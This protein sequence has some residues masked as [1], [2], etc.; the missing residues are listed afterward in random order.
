MEIIEKIRQS[1]NDL[2]SKNS[3][4]FVSLSINADISEKSIREIADKKREPTYTERLILSAMF[5]E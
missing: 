3:D 1:L 2:R 5:E 4:A